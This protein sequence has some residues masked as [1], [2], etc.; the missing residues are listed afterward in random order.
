MEIKSFINIAQVKV[1]QEAAE[2]LI[3]SNLGSCLGIGIFDPENGIAG[4]VHCLLPL[5]KSDPEK[6]EINPCLYVD[7]GFT[8]LLNNILAQ[9]ATKQKLK[10]FVAG[11]ANI[12]DAEHVFEIGKK[13][14]TVLKKILS[15]NGL[16][17]SAEDVGGEFS[18]TIS[19]HAGTGRCFIRVNG[20]TKE[21]GN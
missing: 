3:I 19:L 2:V 20:E 9:G 16:L 11:G 10:I 17:L 12:N 21:L 18:R 14:F 7:T 6:A 8:C 15:K 5:S 1:T 13:N 4:M